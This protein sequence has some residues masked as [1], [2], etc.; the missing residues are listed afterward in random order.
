MRSFADVERDFIRAR[1]E[2]TFDWEHRDSA[3]PVNELHRPVAEAT[4]ALVATAGG[5]I[6][7]AQPAFARRKEGDA[8]FRELPGDLDL[9]RLALSHVGYDAAR[10]AADVNVVFPLER[11]RALAAGGRI[12]RVAPRHLSFMGYCLDT[13]ALCENAREVARRLIAD[14]VELALLVP[15]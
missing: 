2:P 13:G 9:S 8:T 10:A 6:A 11:L 7:G 12:G 4:V 1:I 3:S 14:Q 5:Y 15:A